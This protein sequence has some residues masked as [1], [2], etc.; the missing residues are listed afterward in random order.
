MQ[1]T[2]VASISPRL[3][4]LSAHLGISTGLCAEEAAPPASASPLGTRLRPRPQ[5]QVCPTR[6]SPT[7]ARFPRFAV[8][9]TTAPWVELRPQAG[10]ARSS[11]V[12]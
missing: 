6:S 10:G 2:G 5:G 8:P 3:S 1:V 7:S 9:Q 4:T 11:L 12:R